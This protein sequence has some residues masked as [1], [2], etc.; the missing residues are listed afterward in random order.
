MCIVSAE[1]K[2]TAIKVLRQALNLNMIQAKEM[3]KR[4]PGIVWEGTSVEVDW[5][6]NILTKRES[7]QLLK[8]GRKQADPL[9]DPYGN[10]TSKTETACGSRTRAEITSPGIWGN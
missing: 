3:L 5:L 10:R 1:T 7:T 8:K 2:A 6:K 4:I 9:V